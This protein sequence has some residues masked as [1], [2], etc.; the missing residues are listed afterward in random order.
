MNEELKLKSAKHNDFKTIGKITWG[1]D[2]VDY[3]K[4]GFN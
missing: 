1:F 4:N 2:P 3:L